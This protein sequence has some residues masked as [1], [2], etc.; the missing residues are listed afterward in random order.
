MKIIPANSVKMNKSNEQCDMSLYLP[1]RI[2]NGQLDV[3]VI[4]FENS[5]IRHGNLWKLKQTYS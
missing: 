4:L 1:Q 3:L 5:Q 2:S